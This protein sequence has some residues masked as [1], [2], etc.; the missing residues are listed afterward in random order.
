MCKYII[1]YN[2]NNKMVISCAYVLDLGPEDL[3]LN[4]GFTI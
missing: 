1:K 2:K 3:D 4:F